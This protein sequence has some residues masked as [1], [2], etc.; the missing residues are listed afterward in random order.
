MFDET[1]STV[2]SET[3]GKPTRDA[4]PHVCLTKKKSTAVGGDVSAVKSS[5]NLA[6]AKPLEFDLFE[7]TL[8]KQKA[9][10][11]LCT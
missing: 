4:E 11:L 5:L 2:V 10:S 7:C 3:L 9:V 8:C 1:H 6:T